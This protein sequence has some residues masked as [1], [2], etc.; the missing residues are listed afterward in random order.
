M[1][2]PA[3]CGRGRGEGLEGERETVWLLIDP[4]PQPCLWNLPSPSWPASLHHLLLS[5]LPAGASSFLSHIRGT[6][7][8]TEE[9]GPGLENAD[10]VPLLLH[11]GLSIPWSSPPPQGPRTTALTSPIGWISKDFRWPWRE[12][13][14]SISP[15]SVEGWLSPWGQWCVCV[16]VRACV[17]RRPAYWS[18]GLHPGSWG[19]EWPWRTAPPPHFLVSLLGCWS[20]SIPLLPLQQAHVFLPQML[21]GTSTSASPSETSQVGPDLSSPGLSPAPGTASKVGKGSGLECDQRWEEQGENHHP[22]PPPMH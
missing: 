10:M 8:L 3:A 15:V 16:C 21:R 2:S 6:S 19:G 4:P 1:L 9:P 12:P 5:R 14:S 13:F 7:S 18:M 20:V 22:A 11:P 17:E